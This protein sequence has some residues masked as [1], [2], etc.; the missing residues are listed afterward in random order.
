MSSFTNPLSLSPLSIECQNPSNA[1]SQQRAK[2]GSEDL[3]I[4]FEETFGAKRR[5]LEPKDWIFLSSKE[6]HRLR[7]GR[8]EKKIHSILAHLGFF[9]SIYPKNLTEIFLKKFYSVLENIPDWRIRRDI[10]SQAAETYQNLNPTDLE[11]TLSKVASAIEPVLLRE[12]KGSCC[13]LAQLFFKEPLE[14]LDSLSNGFKKIS[15]H[16]RNDRLRQEVIK[17]LQ[18]LPIEKREAYVEFFLKYPEDFK[19]DPE[20]FLSLLEILK[21]DELLYLL[22]NSNPVSRKALL[23]S[24]LEKPQ[25]HG[26]E[27]LLTSDQKTLKRYHDWFE[28]FNKPKYRYDDYFFLM[29]ADVIKDIDYFETNIK[30][31]KRHAEKF[32]CYVKHISHMTYDYRIMQETSFTTNFLEKRGT[33]WGALFDFLYS[34]EKNCFVQIKEPFLQDLSI[35]V[36]DLIEEVLARGDEDEL[37]RLIELQDSYRSEQ[38]F[39]V[40]PP[41]KISKTNEGFDCLK[42][43]G[44]SLLPSCLVLV[45]T[46]DFPFPAPKRLLELLITQRVFEI[47]TFQIKFVSTHSS[48]IKDEVDIPITVDQGG[49]KRQCIDLLTCSLLDPTAQHFALDGDQMFVLQE[50]QLDLAKDYVNLGLWIR[51]HYEMEIPLAFELSPLFFSYLKFSLLPFTV[52][53]CENLKKLDRAVYGPRLLNRDDLSFDEIQ[54][55]KKFLL[56]EEDIPLDEIQGEFLKSIHLGRCRAIQEIRRGLG[57]NFM[58][59]VR[60]QSTKKIMDLVQS[61]PVTQEKLL[62]KIHFMS[63][64]AELGDENL[65]ETLKSHFITRIQRFSKHELEGLIFSTTGSMILPMNESKIQVYFLPDEVSGAQIDTHRPLFKCSTCTKKLFLYTSNI[66]QLDLALDS[67]KSDLGFNEA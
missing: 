21:F 56:I 62:E 27:L 43:H 22:E 13:S 61:R 57:P 44:F 59:E 47:P 49:P 34:Y 31:Y 65:Y 32:L 26:L 2:R 5:R 55:L 25:I 14:G 16:L 29:V 28:A 67:L 9:L 6:I 40:S 63:C 36:Q 33:G 38:I 51:L 46:R 60:S 52:P 39:N 17:I 53:D 50:N 4:L 23:A 15:M 19:D 12:K 54:E 66:E 41:L 8:D 11:K 1:N 30:V 3:Q 7:G 45:V 42:T 48:R 20:N 37:E 64:P 18:S 58:F 35:L 10:L 24:K